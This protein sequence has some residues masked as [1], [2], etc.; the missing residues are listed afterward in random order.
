[1]EQK[2]QSIKNDSGTWITDILIKRF[3]AYKE[4][5]EMAILQ[6]DENDIHKKL[7]AEDNS[8]AIIVGHLQGNML[9]RFTDFLKTDGEKRWR[10]RDAEFEEK[11]MSKKELLLLWNEGWNCVLSTMRSLNDNDLN[12]KVT[13]RG[14]E[15]LVMDAVVRQIAHYAY[16]V[17]QIVYL[18]KTVKGRSWQSLSIPKG[19]SDQYNKS[20]EEK[21]K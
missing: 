9:S 12:K 20:M 14:E 18:A 17:G 3:M 1:M 21:H 15:H 5:G 11:A 8:I 10:N 16:H 7:Q 13:I 6:L 19:G 2:K 4:L